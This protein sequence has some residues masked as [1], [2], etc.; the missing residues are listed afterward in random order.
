[1]SANP[2][3]VELDEMP[4]IVKIPKDA[5]LVEL[6]ITMLDEHGDLMRVQRCLSTSEIRECRKD[7]LDNVEFGDDYDAMYTLTDE[8]RAYAEKL[9]RG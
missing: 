1:M 4:I 8:G 5:A 6:N 7:F 9:L 3:I 2:N